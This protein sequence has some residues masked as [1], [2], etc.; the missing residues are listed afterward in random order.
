MHLEQ[1]LKRQPCEVDAKYSTSTERKKETSNQHVE[2]VRS[3]SRT[4]PP[5]CH[6]SKRLLL[7]G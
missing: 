6:F 7:G 4:N 1:G 2:G 5:G 3:E